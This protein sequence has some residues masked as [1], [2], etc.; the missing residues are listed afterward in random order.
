MNDEVELT[1]EKEIHG[2]IRRMYTDTAPKHDMSILIMDS[3]AD[4]SMVGKGF[5]ILF[6]TG[7]KMTVCGA[8]ASLDSKVYEI[9]TAAT[10]VQSP[11]STQEYIVII[12]QA[13]Y[14]PD[15]NQF[16]SLLH[17]DQARYHNVI[18]N[19]LS[20]FLR[21]GNGNIGKQS[22][23]ADGFEIP[24]QH[25]GSK[26]F[27]SIRPPK[28]SDW[29]DL[30]IIEL[31]SPIPWEYQERQIR[32]TRKN[33]EIPLQEIQEWSERLGHLNTNATKRTLDATTQMIGDVEAESRIT[34]RKHLKTRLPGLRP[35]R[36]S[37]GFH[38][39][40]FFAVERSARGNTCAQVFVGERSGY[41][42]VIPLKTKG[43]AYI[44]LQD[45]IRY[46]GAP[47][48]ILV[49]SAPEENKGEWLSTC[50]TYCIP[51]HATEPEYQNQNRAERRIGDIKRRASLLMS[52]HSTPERYW[53]YAVEYAVE[54][55]NHTAIE[56]L[57]WRTPFETLYGDTPDISI[58]RFIFYEPIY[59][60]DTK[61][62]F[63]H[64][65]M[66]PGRFL[67]IARTTG[68]S[69][70]F[71][72]LTDKQQERNAV[73]TRSVIRKRNPL[74]PPQY[75][76]YDY[77]SPL[78]EED[79][80]TDC[81]DT[82]LEP[83]NITHNIEVNEITGSKDRGDIELP[84][85]PENASLLTLLA[86]QIGERDPEEI[87]LEEGNKVTDIQVNNADE[88]I[89]HMEDGSY[90]R[91]G[92]EEI[93]NHIQDEY[94]C[95]DIVEL[96]SPKYSEETGKLYITVKWK[97]GNESIVDA[98]SLKRD[99]PLR[100][101]K[102]I[103]NHPA[104]RLRSGYWNTWS[105]NILINNSKTLRRI[106]AIYHQGNY[107]YTRT[108]LAR[109]RHTKKGY[110]RKRQTQFGV[111]VPYD[112]RDAKILDKDNKNNKWD[113]SI[114]K[115]MTGIRE[116][117]TFLFLP[118]GSEPPADYQE[119]SLRM[120]FSVKPDLRRKARLV[121]GGHK[122]DSSEYNCH[123]SVVQLSSIRLL[124]VIARAQGLECLA[125]DI[126]NAYINAD[127]KEKIFVR[128]G[129]EFG[130]E[131][132]GRIAILK[133][134]LYGLKSSG[135]RWHAHFAKTLYN[136]GFE[137]TRYDNDV[138]IKP[139]SDESGYDYICTYVDDFLI[140]AK[141]AWQ[142]MR[143][144]QRIYNIKDPKH[145]EIYLGALY[146]GS[147]KENWTI[148][149]KNY[150]KEA[151][152]QVE[153]KTG[154]KIREEKL[155]MKPGDHPEE[156]E[157]DFLDNDQHRLYQSMMGMLQWTVSIGRLDICYAV[158]SL[159]RFCTNPREGHLERVY[160]IFGYLRKYPN[161]A[162]G[163]V[164]RDPIVNKDLLQD[165]T[166]NYDF[167]DQYAY[168]HEEIDDRFPEPKGPELPVSIFFDSD[169]AHDKKTGRSISGVITMVGCTPISWKSR[170]QGAIATSTYGAEFYAMKLATEEAITI[171]YMLRSL[172]IPV[173]GP[174]H[175]YGD[176][177]SVIQNVS[178]P[179][180]PLKKKN[181]ALCFHFVRENVATKTIRPIKL[182]SKDNFADLLTKPL[183]RGVFMSHVNGLLWNSPL[184]E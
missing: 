137:P 114:T 4:A 97:D 11:Q 2:V 14:V 161:K 175:M 136:M 24:L 120:I 145:P 172:G 79:S 39:D 44:A 8:M 43:Q 118:P 40:T 47:S 16:E 82:Q 33:R 183:I 117:K 1:S 129:P 135:N 96:I 53:D 153:Q 179:E 88:V 178:K 146:T 28:S 27:L 62:R 32:R 17:T 21:D 147:P 69:F 163:I 112:V 128:C 91:M 38:S 10:V 155:P 86:K 166:T 70:T 157:S 109:M 177:S 148:T 59:Y 134:A 101:A 65:N 73:L 131:L 107:H 116:H 66:L 170:R 174:C 34:P 20:K 156:D 124:N 108:H 158:S 173:T 22:I 149:A 84:F 92:T 55:I 85:E 76:E 100:L 144:L 98:E 7:E 127:T 18:I 115:E 102:F 42:V 67:G 72:I 110:I 104:E 180:S 130:P 25:D 6:Y 105:K 154:N 159:S 140:I 36:L 171:R 126:G 95:E 182:G 142:Y 3:A 60:L 143:E 41:T 56:R 31:T 181:L 61:A 83:S 152:E 68:D 29:N 138:W 160:R 49:D 150:I 132:E 71:Y 57:N 169:H 13:A 64:P 93:Y 125:G 165:H 9:V 106:N 151:I 26:Y 123:S 80:E 141:D 35:R 52:L 167:E 119:A 48:F 12:N 81:K 162:I 45:F 23:E 139:R 103:H 176:S 90:K 121:L 74:D 113:E 5:E 133:K 78:E 77:I 63:P 58:F 87:I 75:T 30:P 164:E 99:E 111:L 94:Q 37:E 89:I 15:Q 54:L 168:A 184:H 122:I 50:R 46:I 51:Q 19:D